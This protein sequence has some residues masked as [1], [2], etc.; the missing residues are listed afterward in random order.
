MKRRGYPVVLFEEVMVDIPE[1][2]TELGPLVAAVG[3]ADVDAG[4]FAD[5]EVHIM[6]GRADDRPEAFIDAPRLAELSEHD[7]DIPS[8]RPSGS[9]KPRVWPPGTPNASSSASSASTPS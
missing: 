9:S 8:R 4:I 7:Q 2:P 5:E 3:R 1:G 6:T